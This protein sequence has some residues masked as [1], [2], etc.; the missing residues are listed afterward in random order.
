MHAGTHIN[1]IKLH[2][3]ELFCM[4]V[5]A[6]DFFR[7][8]TCNQCSQMTAGGTQTFLCSSYGFLVIDALDPSPAITPSLSAHH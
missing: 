5:T 3:T 2:L 7:G 1:K 4:Q 6:D 8:A